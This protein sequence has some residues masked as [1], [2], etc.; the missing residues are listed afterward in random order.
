MAIRELTRSKRDTAPRQERREW[1]NAGDVYLVVDF[2]KAEA[3][4]QSLSVS[5]C[6]TR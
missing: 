6:L 1:S 4:H 3:G 5:G 2:L